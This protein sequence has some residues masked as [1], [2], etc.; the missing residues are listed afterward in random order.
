[1]SLCSAPSTL[2]AL[3]RPRVPRGL[4]AWTA[5]ARSAIGSYVMA[6]SIALAGST[7]EFDDVFERRYIHKS[8]ADA[9]RHPLHVARCEALIDRRPRARVDSI[10]DPRH[11][12]LL[13]VAA[14]C[15]V[16]PNM[17]ATRD[18]HDGRFVAW[19]PF[20]GDNAQ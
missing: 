8:L 10:P 12:F 7:A 14:M 13:D 15:L 17:R 18:R 5:L 11:V 9:I 6:G 20:T 3:L 4:R 19:L 1:M 2:F 16:D